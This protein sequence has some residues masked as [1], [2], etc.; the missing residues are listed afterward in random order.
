MITSF[1]CLLT[2]YTQMLSEALPLSHHT[3]NDTTFTF[4]YYYSNTITII[5]VTLLYQLLYA[6]THQSQSIINNNV[7]L[8]KHII[9][10]Y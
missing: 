6:P 7:N 8:E 3:N 1:I 10:N 5:C 9:R 4:L 2:N